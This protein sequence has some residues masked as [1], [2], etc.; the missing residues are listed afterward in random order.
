MRPKGVSSVQLGK[1]LGIEQKSAWHLMHRIRKAWEDDPEAFAVGPV[2]ADET[3]TP[4][5]DLHPQNVGPILP[6]PIA[7]D[8]RLADRKETPHEE[9]QPTAELARAVCPRRR[10]T[11]S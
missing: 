6:E 10:E 3:Y 11:A 7:I 2:E 1:D 9:I 8:S 5:K 4:Y